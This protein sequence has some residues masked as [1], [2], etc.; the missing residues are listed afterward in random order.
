MNKFA[1]EKS[2]ATMST[3]K[4]KKDDDNNNQPNKAATRKRGQM[5]MRETGQ[6]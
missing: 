6:T 3:R 5:K 2:T 4:Q 1:I